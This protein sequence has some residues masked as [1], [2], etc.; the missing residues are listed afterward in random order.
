MKRYIRSS[1]S[2][3]EKLRRMIDFLSE[4]GVD[5][6][7]MLSFLIDEMTS[8]EGIEKMTKLADECDVDLEEFWD[9]FN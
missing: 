4:E 7:T 5:E 1:T 9:S 8:D 2:K 6:H 3:T